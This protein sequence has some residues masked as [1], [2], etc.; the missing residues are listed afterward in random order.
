MPLLLFRQFR[1]FS[2]KIAAFKNRKPANLVAMSV[3]LPI[4]NLPEPDVNL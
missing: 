2:G 3:C 1:T 4:V